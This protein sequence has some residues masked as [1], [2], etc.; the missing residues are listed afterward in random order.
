MH[1]FSELNELKILGKTIQKYASKLIIANS[2][3]QRAVY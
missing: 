1:K 3:I 2:F